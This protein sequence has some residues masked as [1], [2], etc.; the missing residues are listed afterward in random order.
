MGESLAC[1]SFAG[2]VSST[3]TFP[4]DVVRRR[5]QLNGQRGERLQYKGFT[6]TI[7][8]IYRKQGLSGFYT[9]ILPEY[10]KV[11]PGVAIA[12]CIYEC[13]KNSLAVQTNKSER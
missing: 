3:I 2:W 4:L 11:V 9:G 5:L 6:D 13:A 12:F 10:Y 7:Q 8:S 1:G